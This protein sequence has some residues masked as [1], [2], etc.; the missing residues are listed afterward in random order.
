MATGNSKIETLQLEKQQL[1]EQIKAFADQLAELSD[2]A[3]ENKKQEIRDLEKQREEKLAELI[4]AIQDEFTTIQEETKKA[5]L[6]EL[7]EK[8]EREEWE[9]MS[10][11]TNVLAIIQQD[12]STSGSTLLAEI[13]IKSVPQ[14]E[15]SEVID[16][17]SIV[18]TPELLRGTE[19]ERRLLNVFKAPE[20]A[21]YGDTP[22]KR[23]ETVF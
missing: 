2:E 16:T 13:Q 10:Y 8:Y 7:L 19:T 17:R 4:A 1:E 6:N 3:K 11:Y 15:H 9:N 18:S 23:L 22:E 12:S 14:V 21:K 20:F 5:A